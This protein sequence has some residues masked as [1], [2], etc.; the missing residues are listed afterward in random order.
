MITESVTLGDYLLGHPFCI[1]VTWVSPQLRPFRRLEAVLSPFILMGKVNVITDYDEVF[2]P[3]I[4]KIHIEPIFHKTHY[5]LNI[6]T[7]KWQTCIRKKFTCLS[8]SV[9]ATHSYEIWCFLPCFTTNIN[10]HLNGV[11]GETMN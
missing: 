10:G 1:S 2:R 5:L 4:P 9:S 7:E 8:V 6:L 3:I 11:I